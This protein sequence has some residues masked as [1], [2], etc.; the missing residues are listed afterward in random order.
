MLKTRLAVSSV[1]SVALDE[2]DN[3]SVSDKS[4]QSRSGPQRS[5]SRSSLA[6]SSCTLGMSTY[7]NLNPILFISRSMV[8]VTGSLSV[9]DLATPS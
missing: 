9:L 4:I 3:D 5:Q 6:F 8:S 7:F 1:F 2:L